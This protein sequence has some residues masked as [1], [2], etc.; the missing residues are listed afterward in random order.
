MLTKA[1]TTP[2]PNAI[3][4]LLVDHVH[5]AT[6]LEL[7]ATG[8]GGD[9]LPAGTCG[10]L[11]GIALVY[12]VVDDYGTLFVR[13]CLAKTVAEKVRNGKVKLFADHG[14]YTD[15]H[16]GTVR[17][18]VDVGDAAVMTAD[19]FDTDAGRTMKAYLEA[20]LASGSETGLSVGFRPRQKEWKVVESEDGDEDMVMHFL[21]IEL[22]EISITPVPAVPGTEVT[23]V[24]REASE[25][26]DALL[27]RTLRNILQSLPESVARGVF[28]TV[29]VTRT[30][31]D[32][33]TPVDTPIASES[34]DADAAASGDE[35]ETTIEADATQPES[36]DEPATPEE[37]ALAFRTSLTSATR[38]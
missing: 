1:K 33:D 18:I 26:D 23:A 31:D 34:T 22:R 3:R 36:G 29:Y 19:L 17:D 9:A 4:A 12:D 21:E 20:V 8:D 32:A 35:G 6:K 15:T 10:R 27:A 25:T 24:R 16:V 38:L 14:P 13:G 11:A 30:E 7:R 2:Q 5:V 28:E 37:R